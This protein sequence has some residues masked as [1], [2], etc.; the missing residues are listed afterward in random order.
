MTSDTAIVLVALVLGYAVVSGLV[1]R[2]YIAPALIFVL[3]GM[4]MGPFGLNLIVETE[5][6]H[7]FT[8]LA[9]LALT[10][11]LFNQAAS[12]DVVAAFRRGHA[13]FRLLVI[14]FPVTLG[15]GTAIA[16][17]LLPQLPLWEAVCLAAIVAPTEVA[18]IDALLDDKR[19]PE[20]VRHALSVE[21]G[22]YDGFALAAL[23]AALALA[24]E[25]RDDDGARW[26]WFLVRTEAL[27]VGI[28]LAVGVVG[29]V[30]IV[31]S[32]RRGW[33]NATWAQLAILATALLCFYA[34]EHAH[35]SGFVAAFVGGLVYAVVIRRNGLELPVQFTDAAGQLLEL[36]VF[37]LFGHAVIVGWRD[38]DW[39]V[40]TFAVLALFAVR[41]V[42]VSIAL[43]RTDVPARSRVFIGWFGPRGIGT[44]VLGLLVV[45]QGA[46][47]HLNV[48]GQVVVVA[49]T[50]SLVVHSLTAPF[51]IRWV[52]RDRLAGTPPIPPK[53]PTP[54]QDTPR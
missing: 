31:W 52:Q 49:I 13:T 44:L 35:A 20:R 43:L 37:A 10:V 11:I 7:T 32:T 47:V 18:L 9:Q 50:L 15:L 36:L 40:I 12:L 8:V 34:G 30:V 28:G 42:A 16:V 6:T 51:G 46:I 21:T 3:A 39:R 1:N 23:L 27:S 5:S 4:A 53:Q 38:A 2:A 24:S 45:E 29:S 33:M 54:Q 26:T 41:L 19:I 48:I 25:R 17:L 22:F 14:G